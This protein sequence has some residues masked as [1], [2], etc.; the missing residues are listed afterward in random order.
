MSRHGRAIAFQEKYCRS[1]KGVGHGQPIRLGRFQK[2]FLE[3]AL[4]DG[5]DAAILTTARGNGKSTEGGGLATWAAFD[6]DDTGAPQVPVV[7]TTVGQAIKS[8][9]GVAVAMIEADPELRSRCQI[10]T[11]ITTPR[12]FVP[13]NRGELFPISH[14]IEGLQGL[15]PSLAII[16]EIGFQPVASYA[17]LKL[18]GGKRERSLLLGLGT[19]GTD[20]DNALENI[21][22]QVKRLGSLP[23]MVYREFSTPAT[24]RIDDR[25]GWRLASPAIAEGFLR[26]SAIASDLALPEGLFR[27]FRLNQSIEG[28]DS[29]L[30]T[31]AAAIWDELIHTAAPTPGARTWVGIDVALKRDSTAVVYVQQNPE[32]GKLHAWSRIWTPSADVPVDVGAVMAHL[33]TLAR[34]FEVETMEYD[35]RFFDVPA[36]TLRIERLPMHEATQSVELMTR[37]VGAAYTAILN[38]ELHHNDDFGLRS[39]VLA[40]KARY[41]GNATGFALEKLKSTNRIDAAIALALAVNA[42]VRAR[43]R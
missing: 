36:N 19:K 33:R 14:D 8:C 5:I 22:R 7:A 1:P 18:A 34:L 30:G 32:C 10:F 6:D 43:P 26:E 12:V 15:D 31:N 24:Y 25:A 41:T 38:G 29:W 3:E 2:E 39:H 42:A 40:A 17:A 21:R 16:D 27:I 37:A 13:Y 23:R 4:A 35:P 9:Y 11:G 28:A 20:P